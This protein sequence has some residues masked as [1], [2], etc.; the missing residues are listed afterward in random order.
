MG[1]KLVQNYLILLIMKIIPGTILNL[2]IFGI[3]LEKAV[4]ELAPI[5]KNL[6][7]KREIFK[8]KLMNGIKK[9]KVKI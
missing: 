5:N 2:R 1:L 8:K 6:I 9:I 3:V 7:K 4:H